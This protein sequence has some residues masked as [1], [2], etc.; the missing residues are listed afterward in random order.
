MNVLRVENKYDIFGERMKGDLLQRM[1][2]GTHPG[3]RGIQA[4]LSNRG[5]CNLRV[6]GKNSRKTEIEN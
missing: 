4:M 2:L 1:T 3:M 6:G 5:G